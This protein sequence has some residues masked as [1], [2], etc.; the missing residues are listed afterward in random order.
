MSEQKGVIQGPSDIS[1]GKRIA[2]L[3]VM[4]PVGTTLTAVDGTITTLSTPVPAF[5][6]KIAMSDS[7]GAV[8]ERFANDEDTQTE[9]LL[10][11]KRIRRGISKICGEELQFGNGD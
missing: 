9:I 3:T 11:L 6:Q 4:L 1:T 2:N 5:I 10:E 8:I 7:D